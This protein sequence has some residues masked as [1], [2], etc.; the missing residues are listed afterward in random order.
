MSDLPFGVPPAAR[1]LQWGDGA[2]S[3]PP[4]SPFPELCLPNKAGVVRGAPPTCIIEG[5]PSF[6]P[7]NNLVRFN[8]ISHFL[9]YLVI[10]MGKK[11]IQV[12]WAVQSLPHLFPAGLRPLFPCCQLT[13]PLSP[14]CFYSH[15]PLK[16]RLFDS[17]HLGDQECSE[18]GW[19]RWHLAIAQPK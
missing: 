1:C 10:L 9:T 11:G 16:A 13:F 3:M 14:Q 4:S 7:H 12:E 8:G 5:V 2:P 17:Q 15:Q 18:L 19:Q 6:K